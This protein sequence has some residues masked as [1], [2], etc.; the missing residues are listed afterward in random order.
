MAEICLASSLAGLYASEVLHV[1]RQEIANISA[2][3]SKAEES[4]GDPKVSN[5]LEGTMS[6]NGALRKL[7]FK[8][9]WA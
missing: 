7:Q 2:G 5:R 4:D 9:R 8:M 3:E 1:L 6:T